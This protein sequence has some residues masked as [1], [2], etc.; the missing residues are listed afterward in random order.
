MIVGENDFESTSSSDHFQ[1]MDPWPIP[2][3]VEHHAWP[4]H[5][6]DYSVEDSLAWLC[7][8]A[9]CNLREP[10]RGKRVIRLAPGQ[11]LLAIFVNKLVYGLEPDEEGSLDPTRVKSLLRALQSNGVPALPEG[12]SYDY[13]L[14]ML[15]AYF[16]RRLLDG[17]PALVPSSQEVLGSLLTAKALGRGQGRRHTLRAS[18]LGLLWR[19]PKLRG[20][21]CRVC[22]GGSV[23]MA[24]DT[25][26]SDH[27][28]IL[29]LKDGGG[30]IVCCQ[31]VISLAF[32][33]HHSPCKSPPYGDSV[34]SGCFKFTV[35]LSSRLLFLALEKVGER[36]ALQGED[37]VEE[38]HSVILDLKKHCHQERLQRA[39]VIKKDFAV[40]IR[41]LD[42]K[43]GNSQLVSS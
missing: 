1:P 30:R 17:P 4:L 37:M 10:L 27:D 14:A 20:R 21:I 16:R 5:M 2:D 15:V 42:R 18:I 31:N 9:K 28:I 41:N 12:A 35:D 19:H 33:L 3:S 8:H 29:C 25:A 40:E 43:V 39:E 6:E 13:I 38:L 36:C 32:F 24:L 22:R 26:A 7:A 34:S 23:A 11:Y